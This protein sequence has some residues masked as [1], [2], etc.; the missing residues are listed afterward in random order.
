MDAKRFL[1]DDDKTELE[2][3]IQSANTAV[4][5]M[6]VIVKELSENDSSVALK[7]VQE[8]LSGHASN[9]DIHFTKNE[10]T[11]LS[12]IEEGANKYIHPA[13]N[14]KASGFYKVTVDGN[15]HVIAATPVTKEDITGLGIS[16][17]D[18]SHDSRYYTE[19]EVDSKLSGKANSGHTHTKSQITDFPTTMPP[20]AHN[21]DDR[22]YTE[23]EVNNLLAGKSNTGHTHDY[24]PSG[25]THDDRYY[26][27]TE[28]N[29]KLSGKSDTGHTHDDRYYTESETNNLLADKAP[30]YT[31]GTT[32][33]TA[34]SSTLTSGRIHLVY[35]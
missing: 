14:S 24:S 30:A 10:R 33:L 34:G 5:E 1:T 35:E 32:D 18:H 6:Y 20:S 27:E 23:S 3:N 13:Y 7:E 25:H 28:I 22:Y 26:T 31:S 2:K 9:N 11:K 19:T 29:S 17:S 15:G 16:S 21:H 8:G 12:G 4:S